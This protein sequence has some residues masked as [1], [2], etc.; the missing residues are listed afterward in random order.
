MHS[1][2]LST[3]DAAQYTGFCEDHIRDMAH[4][5]IA[6]RGK[7]GLKGYQRV[8]KGPWRFLESDIHAFMRQMSGSALR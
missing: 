2:Y 8:V 4:L 1:R 6:T 7:Q 3:R 5:Y